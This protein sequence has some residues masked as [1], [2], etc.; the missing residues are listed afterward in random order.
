MDDEHFDKELLKR[1][2][3]ERN[4]Q[5]R[6]SREIS[7]GNVLTIVALVGSVTSAYFKIGER[8]SLIEAAVAS[9]QVQIDRTDTQLRRE[10]ERVNGK[11]D[12]LLEARR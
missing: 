8:I 6:F 9:Q 2:E 5:W 1:D 7:L 3:R 10:L 11:L 12:R 4:G